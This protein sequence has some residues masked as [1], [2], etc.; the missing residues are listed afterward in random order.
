MDQRL[1]RMMIDELG[2]STEKGSKGRMFV[3]GARPLPKELTRQKARK[4][5]VY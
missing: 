1:A 3:I 4:E 5:K 2:K